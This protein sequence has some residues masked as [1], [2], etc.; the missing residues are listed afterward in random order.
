MRAR[1]QRLDELRAPRSCH[2]GLFVDKLLPEQEARSG[3]DGRG[4][5][6]RHLLEAATALDV[7]AD[8]LLAFERR[9]SLLD[10]A[11]TSDRATVLLGHA[12]TRGRTIVGL[13]E[14]SV[15]EVGIT[16]DHTWGV[17]VLP[18][19]ALKGLAASAAHHL[20]E[21]EA[22]R[23]EGSSY[24]ELFGSTDEAGRVSFLDAWWKPGSAPAGGASAVHLDV[25]TVHHPDYYGK[26]GR[27]PSDT[28]SPNPISF[29]TTSGEFLVAVEGP[30]EWCEAAM[31]LLKLGLDEL[32]IGAKTNAGY[33]RMSLEWESLEERRQRRERERIDELPLHERLPHL[34]ADR[35]K[36]SL[37]EQADW[38]LASGRQP[39]EGATTAEWKRALRSTY[40]EAIEY[41]RRRASDDVPEEL[42]QAREQLEEH[43]AA[44]PSDKKLRKK[45]NKKRTKLQKELEK[46]ERQAANSSDQ[47]ER[48][49]SWL[50]WVEADE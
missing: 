2:L 39:Q 21:D 34:H 19:S 43:E 18:G 16:L 1:R 29:L 35:L 30:A 36:R 50:R 47:R 7:P 11:P 14:E 13:G 37:K 12:T 27:P 42:R 40:A 9:R 32:G 3:E 6:G 17:P 5:K 23:R 22:W 49:Q 38:L 31:Q 44:K 45:W 28:D 10:A 41:L 48:I 20:V 46:R 26:T 24:R 25:M 4:G 33:G 8:Y 15:L